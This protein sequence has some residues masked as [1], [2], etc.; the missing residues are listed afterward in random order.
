MTYFI[1]FIC[2]SLTLTLIGLTVVVSHLSAEPAQG[3][4]L[5]G[6]QPSDWI[7]SDWINSKLLE[8]NDLK[9]KVVLVRFWTGPE[10][11]FC[12]ASAPSLNE[13]Y[14][15]YHGQ[16]LEVI[17]IYHHKSPTPVSRTHVQKL[18]QE[19]QFK[20][21]VAIDYDWKTL[22]RWWLDKRE[23][24]WTSVSFLIDRSGMIRYIHPGGQYVKG[25]QDYIRIESKINEL[26]A[27]TA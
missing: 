16:G 26:L 6:T 10:C 18:V 1:R 8:L 3:D 17:G 13:F 27:E 22:R 15:K 11:P 4:D 12:R 20:F 25:D 7:L 24:P 9:G 21:P 5:I 14:E 23:R 2:F 19:Y